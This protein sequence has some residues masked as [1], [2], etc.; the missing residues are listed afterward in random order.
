MTVHETELN[1]WLAERLEREL[2]GE[3]RVEAPPAEVIHL[4]E[5]WGLLHFSAREELV[6]GNRTVRH[7]GELSVSV[8]PGC[9][10]T[11]RGL[12]V[13]LQ[14]ALDSVLAEMS[15]QRWVP[16]G[17]GEIYVY[18]ARVNGSR[19]SVEDGAWQLSADFTLVVQY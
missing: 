4:P 7:E 10:G 12:S 1:K 2:D 18:E 6:P 19:T 13:R 15:L 11:L 16:V 3:L 14:A 8:P 17:E 5:V 9:E